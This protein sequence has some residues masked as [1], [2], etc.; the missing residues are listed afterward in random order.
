MLS[1]LEQL[2]L[3]HHVC[4]G[5]KFLASKDLVHMFVLHFDLIIAHSFSDLAARNVLLTNG[6]LAKVADFGLV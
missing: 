5:M 4:N 1:Y 3:A 6:N 2:I